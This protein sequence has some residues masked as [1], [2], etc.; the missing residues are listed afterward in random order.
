VTPV[1]V[2]VVDDSTV[3]RRLVT[4]ALEED[5]RIRVVGSAANGRLALTKIDQLAPDVVTLDLEMPV[6]D[7]IE[8]LKV[9]RRT[10]PDL[11]VVVFSTLTERGGAKTLDALS[12][13]AADY[14][15]KPT[16]VRN[17]DDAVRAAREQLAPKVVSL[18]EAAVA[19]RRLR[20]AP[21]RTA[22]VSAAPTAPLGRRPAAR[23]D[24][25]ALGCSTGGPEALA[26]IVPKLPAD[27]PVPIVVVQHM[28]RLFTRLLAQRLDKLGGPRVLEAAGG[29]VLEA[30]H[31]YIAPGERHLEVARDSSGVVVTR[32]S[33]APPENNCRPSVDVL[34]RAVAAEYGAAALGVVLTGMGSDGRRGSEA[35][36][37]AGSRVIVQDEASSVVWGMPRAVF[38]AGI[39]DQVL[40]LP[41][42]GAAMVERVTRTFA[43]AR[44]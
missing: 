28:P 31:I 41:A 25:V 32:L 39:A 1:S 5:P 13:G 10:H 14:V 11:P 26:S 2:L 24:V 40:P 12:A 43:G 29:E 34:F 7:G 30:G 22:A 17:L 27:L 15:T 36:V 4:T 16:S 8:V 42:V 3:I 9:L 23:I 19:R 21:P 6:M 20:S 18:H 38:D 44:R 35:L 37:A 33:T